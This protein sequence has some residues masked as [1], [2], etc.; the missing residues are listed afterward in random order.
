MLLLVLNSFFQ[1]SSWWSSKCDIFRTKKEAVASISYEEWQYG[2]KKTPCIIKTPAKGSFLSLL[3]TKLAAKEA[4]TNS[5]SNSD[6]GQHN[7]AGFL[8]VLPAFIS[9]VQMLAHFSVTCFS[10]FQPENPLCGHVRWICIDAELLI[11]VTCKPV[12]G[13]LILMATPCTNE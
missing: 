10:C 5:E 9:T 6:P 2:Q 8:A 7:E 13:S 12:S 1:L 3:H 11:R 4:Q